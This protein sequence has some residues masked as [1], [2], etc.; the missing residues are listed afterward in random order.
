ML[1]Y[2]LLYKYKQKSKKLISCLYIFNNYVIFFGFYFWCSLKN[3]ANYYRDM[4]GFKIPSGFLT[5]SPIFSLEKVSNT[6]CRE[7]LQN[8]IRKY[9]SIQS[10]GISYL[11]VIF[12]SF[13]HDYRV[14]LFYRSLESPTFLE[15][16]KIY[17]YEWRW[18]PFSVEVFESNLLMFEK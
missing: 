7:R 6:G 14:N 4:T 17:F 9:S 10:I 18:Y 1:L 2:W 13:M 5:I 11:L 15:M 16:A 12:L 8:W 3:S